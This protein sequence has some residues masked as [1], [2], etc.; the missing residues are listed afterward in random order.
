MELTI[1]IIPVTDMDGPQ[2]FAWFQFFLRIILDRTC[3]FCQLIRG[4]IQL[5]SAQRI[6]TLCHQ[7]FRCSCMY[8][9]C[10]VIGQIWFPIQHSILVHAITKLAR[11]Q[12]QTIYI[13]LHW[14]HTTWLPSWHALIIISAPIMIISEEDIRGGPT[15]DIEFSHLHLL[16]DISIER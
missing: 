12:V 6:H 2:Q 8:N 10:Y 5:L 1:I 13:D 15:Y 4:Q 7:N 16:N 3:L 14:A 9:L 11:Y